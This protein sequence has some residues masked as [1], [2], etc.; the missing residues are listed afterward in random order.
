MKIIV[1]QNIPLAEALFGDMGTLLRL[2]GREITAADCRDA[3]ILL[4]RSITP[5]NEA[6]LKG[7]RVKFVGSCTIGVDHLDREYL[8][9]QG[10]H[11]ASAPGC[12]ANAV[13]QYVL[14]AMAH[15]QPQWLGKRVGIIGCGNIGRRLYQRLVA[16]GV[17]CCCYDPFLADAKD[18][19][20]LRLVS[21]EEVLKA[22][23]I[24]C[25][26]PLTQ[27]GPHPTYHLLGEAELRQL[28]TDTLLM[29][30]GRGPVI[31]NRAL[32]QVLASHPLKVVLDVWE[33]EPDIDIAL[34]QQVTLAT[35]HIAGYSLEG[36]EQ[37]S[38]MI[39]QALC[40]F[41]G[42]PLDSLKR[43]CLSDDCIELSIDGLNVSAYRESKPDLDQQHLLN[44]LLLTCYPIQED[45]HRLRNILKESAASAAHRGRYFD[46]LRKTYPPRREY[47][48]F[49]LPRQLAAYSGVSAL[50]SSP[51]H[52]R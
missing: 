35:P 17:D 26:T 4:V 39:Y 21:F 27:D 47:Q 10:I 36:K 49:V 19:S 12:N 33:Q 51:C 2:P 22:D 34:L 50:F 44:R 25:H 48:H 16:L 29:N 1:D 13:V 43:A 6:L 3:D 7:S 9:E 41:L 23:I 32:S 40:Q 18:N 46:H 24:S 45:D 52:P 15:A 37:G 38:W 30:S 8:H 5:V 14:S 31:D 28:S 42:Q 20:G 11:W